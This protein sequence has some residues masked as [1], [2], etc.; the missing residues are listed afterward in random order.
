VSVRLLANENFPRP[1]LAALRA[2]G[3]DVATLFSPTGGSVRAL[4]GFTAALNAR[5][6]VLGESSA[7]N[8]VGVIE[9]SD[10]Q[11]RGE[12]LVYSAHMDHLGVGRP[13]DGD[14][15][16]NGADDNASGTAGVVELAEAFASL[17]PRPRTPASICHR[18]TMWASPA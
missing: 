3:V 12:A 15:I 16:F 5:R 13:V 17:S 2:A 4:D 18:P 7:P 6:I 1:A 8:V 9:G 14:S 11:L 10:P